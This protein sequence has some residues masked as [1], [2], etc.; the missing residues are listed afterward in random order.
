MIKIKQEWR[1]GNAR[2]GLGWSCNLKKKV[3]R[4]RGEGVP[5][6]DMQLK[7]PRQKECKCKG[8]EAG[9]GLA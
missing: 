7:P 2:L 9:I 3:V 8:P 6:R 4:K 5:R 1:I